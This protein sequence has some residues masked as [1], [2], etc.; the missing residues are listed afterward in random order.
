MWYRLKEK[1]KSELLVLL[2]LFKRGKILGFSY[3]EKDNKWSLFI[4]VSG[5]VIQISGNEKHT[6]KNTVYA[7][8]IIETVPFQEK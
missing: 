7:S 6:L 1:Y 3:E 5:G 2:K 4:H 8:P